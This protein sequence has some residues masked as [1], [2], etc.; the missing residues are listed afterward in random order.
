MDDRHTEKLRFEL[1]ELLRRQREILDARMFGTASD[2][3]VLEYEIRQD[4]IREI[5]HELCHGLS[6]SAAA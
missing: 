5:I 3:D 6:R 4:V 1:N 2:A